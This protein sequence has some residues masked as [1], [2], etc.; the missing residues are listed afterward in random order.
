MSQSNQ[1][2]SLRRSARPLPDIY[3]VLMLIAI[4]ALLIAIVF[5]WRGSMQFFDSSNPFAVLP[6]VGGTRL[7]F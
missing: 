2:P 1:G 3:S 6:K 5:L 4:L 7:L